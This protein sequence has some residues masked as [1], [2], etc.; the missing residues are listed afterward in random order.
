MPVPVEQLAKRGAAASEPAHECAPREVE[1]RRYLDEVEPSV[2]RA[3]QDALY[4]GDDVLL[5]LQSALGSLEPLDGAPV[6]RRIG[7]RARHRQPFD[8]EPN[9]SLWLAKDD[10]TVQRVGV[11]V[12]VTRGRV[13]DLATGTAHRTPQRRLDQR[14]DRVEQRLDQGL[15]HGRPEP[16]LRFH[17]ER[18]VPRPCVRFEPEVGDANVRVALEDREGLRERRSA[19]RS[20]TERAVG[21]RIEGNGRSGGPSPA[22]AGP[23][24]WR[25]V[26]AAGRA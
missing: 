17:S 2:A 23:P 16:Q 10:G 15:P 1:L 11:V 4:L 19:H 21:R 14:L 7:E 25:P 18:E 13:V 24:G 6:Q 8:G 3:F 20:D 9:G 5:P 12:C 26:E 22:R